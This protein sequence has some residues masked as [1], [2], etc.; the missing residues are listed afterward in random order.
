MTRKGPNGWFIKA[1]S[2][3]ADCTGEKTFLNENK[4]NEKNQS[5]T[6][7]CSDET[8]DSLVS[9]F[10]MISENDMRTFMDEQGKSVLKRIFHV[11]LFILFNH[12][13]M[14][15]HIHV[16]ALSYDSYYFILSII[17]VNSERKII[18]YNHSRVILSSPLLY[19]TFDA[20]HFEQKVF[21][22]P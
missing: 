2:P 1:G 3:V 10:K 16:M 14:H 21:E 8:E 6:M 13:L 12:S 20:L 18:F 7:I 22:K 5:G 19:L 9:L 15:Y 11:F 17:G 4:V